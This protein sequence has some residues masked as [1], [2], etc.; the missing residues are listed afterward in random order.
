MVTPGRCMTSRPTTTRDSVTGS[1]TGTPLVRRA[2][3]FLS[4]L[5]VARGGRPAPEL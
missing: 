5:V 1:S 2:G 3:L 4:V